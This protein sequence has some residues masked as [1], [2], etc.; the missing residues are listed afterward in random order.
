MST[1]RWL[2]ALRSRSTLLA[3]A[4]VTA[5]V[6]PVG[7]ASAA[8]IIRAETAEYSPNTPVVI[9]GS[10]GVGA[11]IRAIYPRDDATV[12]ASFEWFADSSKLQSEQSST[13]AL[14]S[15]HIGKVISAKITLS[16]RG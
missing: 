10:Y 16:K 15:A 5:L 14:T 4:L 6:A 8:P 2:R 11:T 3:I 12:S 13:L 9:V 7:A 1:T